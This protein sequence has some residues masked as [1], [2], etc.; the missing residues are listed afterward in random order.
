[1]SNTQDSLQLAIER[2]YKVVKSNEIIQKARVDLGLLEQKTFCYCV[3]KIKPQDQ[4]GTEYI[5]TINEYCTVCGINRNDGRTIENVKQALK[6]LRDKSFY[7]LD[8]NGAWITIGWLS[9]VKVQPK[10]GKIK[11]KFDE[12]MQK[13]LVGLYENYTQ[14]ALLCV[15]PMR[16]GY[17]IRIYELLKSYAGQRRHRVHFDLDELKEK[18]NAKYDRFPDFR[19]YV[20]EIATKEINRYSDIEVTWE[21]EKKG[22]KVI[23][24]TFIIRERD[25]FGRL[26]NFERGK[27]EIDGQ[28]SLS[29]YEEMK[30]E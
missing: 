6:S 28:L 24:L 15:L 3:S 29:D 23:G 2:D 26:K 12:D 14:Y 11:I 22:R 17:S 25:T 19:R 18:L 10:S 1:M 20:L 27:N 5:F 8:E 21:P 4:A 16:S 7:T 13:Y 30:H 9:K